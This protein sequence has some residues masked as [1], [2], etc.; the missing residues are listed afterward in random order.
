MVLSA[1]L[2]DYSREEPRLHS[3]YAGRNP[4]RAAPAVI[5]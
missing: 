3:R 4:R 5:G 2:H 1:L